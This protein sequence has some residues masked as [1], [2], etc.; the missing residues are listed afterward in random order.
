[1]VSVLAPRRRMR[2]QIPP[3]RARHP[4][5]STPNAVQSADLRREDASSGPVNLLV[6]EQDAALQSETPMTWPSSA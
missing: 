4:R 2:Q 6:A 3:G 5:K 1:M